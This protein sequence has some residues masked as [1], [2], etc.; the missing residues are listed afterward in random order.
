MG[1]ARLV[2]RFATADVHRDFQRIADFGHYPAIANDVRWVSVQPAPSPDLPRDSDWEIALGGSGDL[3]R[4]D[5]YRQLHP[6]PD[7]T[8]DLGL[9]GVMDPI[10]ERVLRRITC[11]VL[12]A[13]FGEVT[14]LPN[15]RT[16]PVNTTGASTP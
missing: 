4:L 9:T 13:L 7:A 3:A 16:A 8:F 1:T 5:G 2:I 6:R 14:I 15:G 12:A 11:S 10:A